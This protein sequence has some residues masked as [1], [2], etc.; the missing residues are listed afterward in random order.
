MSSLQNQQNSLTSIDERETSD[1]AYAP[2][3]FN[4]SQ[5]RSQTDEDKYTVL[6]EY[7]AQESDE[8]SV[9]RGEVVQVLVRGE[10]GWWTVE[11]NGQTGLV[12]GNYL[13]KQ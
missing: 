9:N 2:L 5:A 7:N 4:T 3:K 11:K 12:P 13:E 6:Y 8:L 10:D 1:D